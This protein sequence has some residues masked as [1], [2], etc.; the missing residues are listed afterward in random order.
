VW[1]SDDQGS[2]VE[3]G[4]LSWSNV[5]KGKP[6]P[7]EYHLYYP[8]NAV[9]E[10]MAVGDLL[11]IALQ[12]DGSLLA[13]IAPAAGSTQNQLL[14]LFGLEA[15]GDQQVT[16]QNLDATHD[17]ELGFA[18][19]RILE[20]LSIEPEEPE[21]DRLDGLIAPYGLVF[22]TTKVFSELARS[23]LPEVS[24]VDDPD[25]ALVDW[26]DREEQ[27]FRRLERRIVAERIGDG[28][29]TSDAVD[30]DGF[31]S[32]SLS[33]QNRR[34]ARAGQALENHLEAVFQAQG[35]RYAR[36]A[37]TENRNKPDFL[38]PGEVDYA[39]PEFPDARLTMLGAK[40]T[41]KDRW[42]QVLSEARRIEHKHLLTLETG[43][44]E[45][46]TDEMQA[47]SLQLVIPRRLHETYRPAQR[48]WLMDVDGFVDLV[49]Q[50][51][52]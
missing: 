46:Q 30:V 37:Q 16:V 38:F 18:A 40:S 44:S 22:P 34:K 29:Q 14:W 21:A 42:R 26:L 28:F 15:P 4:F 1:L 48:N 39:N 9:T 49:R 33:V 8:S 31:L 11:V 13:V 23:S 17:T 41:L 5:R 51:Q 36:G 35:I 24:A 52:V 7:P 45:N 6:R 43:I 3:D 12:R 19:R 32:F 2:L 25:A 50:R 47:K 27:L 10:A 20:L